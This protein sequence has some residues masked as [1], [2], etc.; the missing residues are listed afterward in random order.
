MFSTALLICQKS[1]RSKY[2]TRAISTLCPSKN[3][4][5]CRLHYQMH[6]ADLVQTHYVVADASVVR[7]QQGYSITTLELTI[8]TL[9]IVMLT[10][11]AMWF[12][13]LQISIVTKIQTKNMCRMETIRDFARH[14]VRLLR[15][16]YMISK[17]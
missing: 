7:L 14:Q 10:T 13:K 16:C 11:S 3:A 1:Q 6:Y 17:T 4:F 9:A 12:L 8:I 15:R 2:V 5:V